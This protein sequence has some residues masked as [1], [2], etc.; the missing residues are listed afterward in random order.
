MRH[1]M[2]IGMLREHA[3]VFRGARVSVAPDDAN[4]SD[5]RF[6]GTFFVYANSEEGEMLLRRAVVGYRPEQR[7]Y[8]VSE[9]DEVGGAEVV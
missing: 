1:E 3:D 9:G 7:Q 8:I 5:F 2:D 6:A 4:W